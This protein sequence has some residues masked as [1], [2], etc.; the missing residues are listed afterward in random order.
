MKAKGI[1]LLVVMVFLIGFVAAAQN[2]ADAESSMHIKFSTWHPPTGREVKTV[3]VPML[4]ELKKQSN[5]RI[6]YTMYAGAA[7]G[8][9]PDHYDIVKNGMS[10]MGYFTATWTPGRFPLTDVLSLATWV[11]GK[12]IAVDIGNEMAK[13]PLKDEFKDVEVMEL[14]GCIQ[15]FIWTKDPVKSLADLKGKKIRSPGGQQTGYIKSLGAEPVFM[16]LGDVY[17]ALETGTIDG[18]VTCPP[19]V[20]GF[21]LYE[22]AKY[23]V[24]TTFGCV[25]EGMVMNKKSWEKTPDDLKP[26]IKKVC[27]NPFRTTGGLNQKVYAQMLE[28]ISGKGVEIYKLPDAE[29]KQWFARFQDETKKWVA[30]LEGKGLPAKATVIEYNK[31]AESKGVGVVAFPEDWK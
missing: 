27:S 5:G 29:A 30:D 25:S 19:L 26:I 16:P 14:N 21:K 4:E 12:D 1:G 10:D 22:V 11:D 28:D 6:T 3:W 13:G 15:A 20:L 24:A 23:G 2:M 17:M 9:G 18:L 31:I 7:L 8:K